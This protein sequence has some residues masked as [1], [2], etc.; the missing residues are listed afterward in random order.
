MTDTLVLH[1]GELLLATLTAFGK[2]SSPK[3]Q[4]T[5]H[6]VFSSPDQEIPRNAHFPYRDALSS[7]GHCEIDLK[8]N[9]ITVCPP[10]LA[11]LPGAAPRRATLVG[12]RTSALLQ[13]IRE[14]PEEFA[15]SVSNQ[16]QLVTIAYGTVKLRL[17]DV[18]ILKASR[19]DTL[20]KCAERLRIDH[21]LDQPPAWQ[22]AC[23]AKSLADYRNTLEWRELPAL[24]PEETKWYDTKTL[25]EKLCFT[26]KA[27]EKALLWK[28]D[29]YTRQNQYWWQEADKAAEVSREWGRWLALTSPNRNILRYDVG[30]RVLVVPALAPLPIMFARALTL[31]SGQA[32]NFI[33]LNADRLPPNTGHL[34]YVGIEKS[35]ADIVSSKLGMPYVPYQDK[36]SG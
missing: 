26:D 18:I 28:Q 15:I 3:Y 12:A 27:P 30:A 2:T 21:A 7:L 22:I 29:I 36:H 19:W 1:T 33:R 34:R 17:P 25:W 23:A 31:S 8:T 11:R 6:S 13:N 16:E 24:A 20:R 10:V 14:L 32:P 4:R 5:F 35:I 9:A